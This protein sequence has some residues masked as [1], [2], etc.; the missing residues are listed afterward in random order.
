M[1]SLRHSF[2]KRPCQE[3]AYTY[4]FGWLLILY[5]HNYFFEIDSAIVSLAFFPFLVG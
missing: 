3:A 4:S 2:I 1:P 5:K